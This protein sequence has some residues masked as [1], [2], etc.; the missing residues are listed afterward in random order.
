MIATIIPVGSSSAQPIDEK[1]INKLSSPQIEIKIKGGWGVHT[2]IKNIGTADLNDVIIELTLDGS[3]IF[4]GYKENL[5][6]I[7]L[8][9]GKTYWVIFPIR[10]F[11]MTNI[12]LTVDTIT[13]TASGHVLGSMIFGVK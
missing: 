5:G 4:P 9:A 6:T 3:L 13:E 11:G 12:E 8:E 7:N 10:G 2:S 1:D